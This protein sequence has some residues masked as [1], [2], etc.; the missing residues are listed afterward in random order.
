MKKRITVVLY[1]ETN[2]E[3]M[4]SDGFIL[5]DLRREINCASNF[6]DVESI[7][8]EDLTSAQPE[9]RTKN[10]RKRTRAIVLADRLYLHYREELLGR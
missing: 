6:Y 8:I 9:K 7:T 5:N 1:V 10:A 2:D 4:V 3:I